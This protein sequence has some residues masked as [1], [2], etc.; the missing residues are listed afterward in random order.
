[1]KYLVV[2][3]C[4]EKDPE[5]L[6]PLPDTLN[7]LAYVLHGKV[8]EKIGCNNDLWLVVGIGGD[9]SLMYQMNCVVGG[10]KGE[11]PR[12]IIGPG[13]LCAYYRH[14]SDEVA[15]V[16]QQIK[17]CAAVF[18]EDVVCVL[19]NGAAP[20]RIAAAFMS[21]Y[22]F[23]ERTPPGEGWFINLVTRSVEPINIYE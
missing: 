7:G 21:G 11:S 8:N 5:T 15:R 10:S 9:T 18:E 13:E 16:A 17:D 12:V 14:N 3:H 1:M 20:S 6:K 23:P 22:D 19:G 4:G 2:L